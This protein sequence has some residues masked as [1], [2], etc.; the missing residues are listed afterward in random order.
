MAPATPSSTE[1]DPR[2]PH[3]SFIEVAKPYIFEQKLQQCMLTMGM[4]EAKE[5]TVRLQGVSWI[6]SVRRSLQLWVYKLRIMHHGI[7]T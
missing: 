1:H 2:G 5:D 6:D 7:D 3:P 4:N